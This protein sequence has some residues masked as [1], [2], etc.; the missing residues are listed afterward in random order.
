MRRLLLALA[1]LALFAAPASAQ[2]AE[3]IVAKF[4]KTV[5]GME[6]IQSVKSLRRTGKYNGG[7]GFEAVIVEENKRPNLVRQE[8]SIQG[9]TGVTAYDGHSGWKIEPWNGKKDAE[10]LGEEEMKGIVE[11][12]DLDGPLVNYQQKGVKVEYVGTDEVEGT[13]AY[14]LKV[15]MPSG[16]VRFYYM[17]TDYFVPIKIDT[18]RMVRG[19]EREYETILGDY[20]EVGGWYL[21]FS[22]ESGP[23]GS[24]FR[25]KVTYEKIEANVGIDDARFREPTAAKSASGGVPDASTIEPKKP[26]SVKPGQTKPA[27]K[28]EEKNPGGKPP[29]R[30]D[31]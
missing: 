6:R 21:P 20:K 11:D 28:K 29:K 17:D 22:V 2:S 25:S 31:E 7:G 27:E 14:K 26:E 24:P 8:F 1:G 9:M 5:G 12:S 4:I 3:E 10:P 13:D 18:K 16:D 15:T 19:A 23:K 30:N